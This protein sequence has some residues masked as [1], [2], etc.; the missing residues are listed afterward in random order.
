MKP[1]MKFTGLAALLAM[2]GSASAAIPAVNAAF[3][4]SGASAAR[5]IPKAIAS[6]LCDAGINDRA[7]YEYT[8]K[9]KDYTIT[10]CTL[11]NTAEVPA[12]IRGQKIAVYTRVAGGSL[13]GVKP[14]A[15]TA[16]FKT[17]AFISQSS[18]PA[19]DANPATTQ[20]CPTLTSATPNNFDTTGFL[21]DVGISDEDGG[22]VCGVSKEVGPTQCTTGETAGIKNTAKYKGSRTYQIV[23]TV[24]AG[25]KASPA[26][27]VDSLSDYLGGTDTTGG[28]VSEAVLTGVFSGAYTSVNQ[29]LK[30]MGQAPLATDKGLKVC[31]RTNTSGT[32]AGQTQLWTGAAFCGGTDAWSFV[33][34]ASDDD[35]AGNGFPLDYDVVEN[36]S[37]GDLETCLLSDPERTIGINSLENGEKTGWRNL[38][39]NNELPTLENAAKGFYPW[40][41]ESTAQYNLDIVNNVGNAP[42]ADPT[43]ATRSTATQR[44]DFATLFI[45]NMSSAAKINSSGLNGILAIRGSINGTTNTANNPFNPANPVAWTTKN[46]VNCRD[47]RPNFPAVG[48]LP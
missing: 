48:P 18:C 42:A 37:S 13:Y 40:Y 46:G 27:T 19:D 44:L 5:E 20:Q 17:I 35:N 23:W 7:D 31:R 29:V 15:D 33:N 38:A 11:K 24:Q 8:S 32:Q 14:V 21:P 3:Y 28:N 34:E 39:I 6:E 36:N 41:H 16:D 12:S 10:V 1:K 25:H 2:A 30:A 47:A 22:F 45:R 4:V 9:P 43:L 26:S